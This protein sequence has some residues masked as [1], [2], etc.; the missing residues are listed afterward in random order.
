MLQ[1]AVAS[2]WRVASNSI[3]L[4]KSACDSEFK[5]YVSGLTTIG[6][7]RTFKLNSENMLAVLKA[8]LASLRAGAMDGGDAPRPTRSPVDCVGQFYWQQIAL[9]V[10]AKI[11]MGTRRLVSTVHVRCFQASNPHLSV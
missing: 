7:R 9:S 2:T 8:L 1:S 11:S 6:L 3:V 10:P 5:A 4:Y